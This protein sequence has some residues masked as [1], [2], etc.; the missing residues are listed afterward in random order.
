MLMPQTGPDE[1]GH[2]A[3]THIALC[4]HDDGHVYEQQDNATH[5]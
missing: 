4:Q 5:R 1:N 2:Q 3:A